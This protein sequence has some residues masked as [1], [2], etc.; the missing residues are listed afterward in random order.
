MTPPSSPYTDLLPPLTEAE[1]QALVDDIRV[2]GVLV[3]VEYTVDGV[4]IDGANRVRAATELGVPYPRVVRS[5]LETQ[6]ARIAHA[7]ALHAHRRHLTPEARLEL[8]A[9]LRSDGLSVRAISAAIGVPK[10]TVAAHVAGVPIGTPGNAET[11]GLDGKTYSRARRKPVG[12]AGITVGSAA[13]QN[14]ASAALTSLAA[15]APTGRQLTLHRAERLAREALLQAART[16]VDDAPMPATIDLRL[17]DFREVLADLPDA[18][19]D[20]VLTDPPWTLAAIRDGIFADV[21]AV[22]S[23]LLRPGGHLAAYTGTQ[24]LPQV[25]ALLEGVKDLDYRWTI[26]IANGDSTAANA[27]LPRVSSR[28]RPVVIY[29]KVGG[30]KATWLPTDFIEGGGRERSLHRWQQSESE[31]EQLIEML[32]EPG[33]LVVDPCAGSATFGVAAHRTRRSFI[34]AEIDPET[35]QIAR[36]RLAQL[37]G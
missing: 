9:R 23:R 36:S 3:A 7:F 26:A 33:A 5:G 6:E 13:E 34:G 24:H 15:G 19:V 25:L 2:R 28:W 22:S 10:S 32:T 4:L 17:G 14:R 8:I 16:N 20:L 27:R 11:V 12:P 35:Y 21:A 31:A 29:R 1:Y 30:E 37:D 18:S